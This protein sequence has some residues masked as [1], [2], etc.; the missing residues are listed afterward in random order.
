MN[1]SSDEDNEAMEISSDE[2]KANTNDEVQFIGSTR[3]TRSRRANLPNFNHNLNSSTR[4]G[5]GSSGES[6][7]FVSK[8][9]NST[10]STD[11]PSSSSTTKLPH[12]GLLP[13]T[14]DTIPIAVN[15]MHT[16]LRNRL[17]DIKIPNF[18]DGT[19]ADCLC[20]TVHITGDTSPWKELGLANM[21]Y[22]MRKPSIIFVNHEDSISRNLFLSMTMFT[23]PILSLFEKTANWCWDITMPDNKNRFQTFTN[24]HFNAGRPSAQDQIA[25]QFP[26]NSAFARRLMLNHGFN[27][28]QTMQIH[29]IAS[30]DYPLFIVVGMDEDNRTRPEIKHVLRSSASKEECYEAILGV[31]E[32]Y[33]E[34]RLF[35]VKDD[36]CIAMAIS[37]IDPRR[38]KAKLSILSFIVQ[39]KTRS[40]PPHRKR[41]IPRPTKPRIRANHPK[42]HHQKSRPSRPSQHPKSHTTRERR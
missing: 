29:G 35:F 2:P 8:R 5:A 21:S 33:S 23:E 20:H 18:I 15:Q 28:D 16:N 42:R 10:N 38:E 34:L 32:E 31:V 27:M 1:I 6:S 12:R 25:N 36:Q 13:E 30:S 4:R 39:T 37:G 22:E 40:P 3:I 9:K 17:K 19:L 7:V 26:G 41:Q 14:Y 11:S 24:K